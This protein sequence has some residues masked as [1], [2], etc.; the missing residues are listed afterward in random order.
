[1]L[2]PYTASHPVGPARSGIPVDNRHWPIGG[3]MLHALS[4]CT[5][6]SRNVGLKLGHRLRR[7][8]NTKP[9]LGQHLLFA[10]DSV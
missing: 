5:N 9:T 8:I 1:M 2:C 10:W 7:W 6:H 4:A 3:L